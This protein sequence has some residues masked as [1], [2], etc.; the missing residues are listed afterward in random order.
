M[1]NKTFKFENKT[2]LHR[3]WL[4]KMQDFFAEYRYIP[5]YEYMGEHFKIGSK[6]TVSKL[7]SLLKENHFLDLGPDSRLIPGKKFF[8]VP[9]SDSA[10]QAGAFTNSYADGGDFFSI[11]E[12]LIR[13]PS[14]TG[15]KPIKGN[16]MSKIGILDGDFA[17]YERKPTA[18]VGE[19]VIAVLDNDYTIKE[20][21]KENGVHILIPHNDNFDIIRPKDG[22]EIEG[23]VTAT[24]RKYGKPIYSGH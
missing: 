16:S 17:I 22:F 8:D 10:V 4:G 15:I 9:F 24:Y 19:I 2:D 18:N 5:S 13:R 11:Q 3:E 6:S 23:V 20:L 7:I 1:T 12:A 14:I 21:G